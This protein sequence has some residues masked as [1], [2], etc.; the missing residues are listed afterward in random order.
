MTLIVKEGM[1]D[2]NYAIEQGYEKIIRFLKE[3]PKLNNLLVQYVKSFAEGNS[4]ETIRRVSKN[5]L[6]RD[7]LPGGSHFQHLL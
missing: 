6:K 7:A 3:K 4:Q 1:K 2:W 5:V